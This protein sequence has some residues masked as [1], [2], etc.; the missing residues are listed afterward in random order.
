MQ[1]RMRAKAN[2]DAVQSGR[3]RYLY[4]S[5]QCELSSALNASVCHL[6]LS[7]PVT[8][9]FKYSHSNSN[10]RGQRER[11]RERAEPG[12]SISIAIRLWA[13]WSG[14][15]FP[16]AANIALLVTLFKTYLPCTQHSVQWVSCG[17]FLRVKAV[18]ACS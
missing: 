13:E 17:F 1:C 9:P 18:G 6:M 11:E 7:R 5:S 4:G 10:I 15:R 14:V 3:S 8:Q 16:A 12:R 2:T